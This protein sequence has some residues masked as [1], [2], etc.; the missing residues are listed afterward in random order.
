[1][2]CESGARRRIFVPSV[3]PL[4]SVEESGSISM[5][6]VEGVLCSTAL[7]RLFFAIFLE[8]EEVSTG[9][10]VCQGLPDGNPDRLTAFAGC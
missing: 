6:H 4:A 7:V 10:G 8:I 9:L 3:G 1:M 5:R 2:T